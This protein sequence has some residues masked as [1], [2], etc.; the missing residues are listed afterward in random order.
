M[1]DGAE[2]RATLKI[3]NLVVAIHEVSDLGDKFE[4]TE[5]IVLSVYDG[6]SD[7]EEANPITTVKVPFGIFIFDGE[8]NGG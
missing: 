1:V 8:D 6:L 2:T 4:G 3:R 5:G 7:V